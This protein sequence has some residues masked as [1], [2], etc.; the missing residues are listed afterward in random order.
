MAENAARPVGVE[1]AETRGLLSDPFCGQVF[2]GFSAQA[3]KI[4]PP[5]RGHPKRT[6]QDLELGSFTIQDLLSRQ[7]ENLGG[8]RRAGFVLGPHN[9][10]AY[11][12]SLKLKKD[13]RAWVRE[14]GGV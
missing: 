1:I 5:G 7:S 13:G 11:G 10:V 2:A 12:S 4:E 14:R 3:A 8:I 6:A 9:A